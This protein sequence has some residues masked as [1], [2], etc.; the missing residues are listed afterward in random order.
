MSEG[1]NPPCETCLERGRKRPGVHKVGAGWLCDPCWRGEGSPA[2]RAIGGLP[3]SV[4]EARRRYR[5]RNR[6]KFRRYQRDYRLRKLVE[7]GAA[8]AENKVFEA[9]PNA[10]ETAPGP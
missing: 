3:P 9:G 7:Q 10:A 8:R 2:E 5:E 1:N 6:A 4:L